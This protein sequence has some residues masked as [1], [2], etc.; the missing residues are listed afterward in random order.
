MI[1][2]LAAEWDAIE[3]LRDD[4]RKGKALIAEVSEK[5]VDIKMPSKYSRLLLPMLNR[6]REAGKKLPGVEAL[7]CEVR[8]IMQKNKRDPSEEDIQKYAWLLRKNCGFIKMKCRRQEDPEFQELC[9]A[10]DPD[11]Q[12]LRVLGVGIVDQINESLAR[13][14][15]AK[16]ARAEDPQV[17]S[18]EDAYDDDDDG[19]DDCSDLASHLS[20]FKAAC[21]ESDVGTERS[22]VPELSDANMDQQVVEVP[23]E[24]PGTVVE[25]PKENRPGTVVEVPKA[26]S[27]PSAVV[28]VPKENSGPGGPQRDAT[29]PQGS[30]GTSAGVK[31]TT[32][33][34]G[35]E[36]D[37][38]EK[39][40]KAD[41]IKQIKERLA[42]LRAKRDRITDPAVKPTTPAPAAVVL[43]GA[44]D[45]A[46]T[47]P[48]D[49][50]AVETPPEQ[51]SDGS[52][53]R[54]VEDRRLEYQGKGQ[55]TK[56]WPGNP[57]SPEDKKVE[58]S[59]PEPFTPDKELCLENNNRLLTDSCV[60]II[61]LLILLMTIN[62]SVQESWAGPVDRVDQLTLRQNKK[63]TDGRGN[64]GR[65]GRGGA[66][67]R[68]RGGGRSSAAAAGTAAD[69][70]KE[71]EPQY[72]TEEWL[73]WYQEPGDYWYETPKKALKTEAAQEPESAM[74]TSKKGNKPKQPKS[75]TEPKSSEKPEEPQ[76]DVEPKSGKKPKE[77][78][79]KAGSAKGKT[80][81][82]AK[83]KGR[84]SKNA[85]S[86]DDV[87]AEELVGKRGRVPDC[88]GIKF[89]PNKKARTADGE[90]T[91]FARRYKPATP[92]KAQRWE[93]IRNCFRT[94]VLPKISGSRTL[95]EDNVASCVD[96]CCKKYI[97][98]ARAKAASTRGNKWKEFVLCLLLLLF[99]YTEDE[100]AQDY[101][102]LEF[103]AGRARTTAAMR[104]KSFKAARFDK[105]YNESVL[106]IYLVTGL[107]GTWFV[108]QPNQSVLEYYPSFRKMI[109]DLYNIRGIRHEMVDVPL[110]IGDSQ[111][112]YP[113]RFAFYLAHHCEL[114]KASA[115]G[116]PEELE[117]AQS[118]PDNAAATWCA[119]DADA[120]L[121]EAPTI[122]E[123]DDE[124]VNAFFGSMTLTVVKTEP[125]DESP[126]KDKARPRG[127]GS[128]A[129]PSDAPAVDSKAP[130]TSRPIATPARAPAVPG[131]IKLESNLKEKLLLA[132]RSRLNRM[133]KPHKKKK[134]LEAPESARRYWE[135]VF[136]QRLEKIITKK[137][138]YTMKVAEGWYSGARYRRNLYDD[139]DEYWASAPVEIPE[140][141]FKGVS[142][143]HKSKVSEAS[144][145]N[146]SS[147]SQTNKDRHI[148][149]LQS[150]VVKMEEQH[151]S[152]A[153]KYLDKKDTETTKRAPPKNNN[154]RP[155]KASCSSTV[156]AARRVIADIGERAAASSGG[157]LELSKCREHDAE[158]DTHRLF[159]ERLHLS[160]EKWAWF[161]G[162]QD[163]PIFS[164]AREGLVSLERT[165]GWPK[166]VIEE[167]G[168]LGL[169]VQQCKD[170]N[171]FVLHEGV[172]DRRSGEKFHA[173]IL[174]VTGDWQWLVKSGKLG[175]NYNHVVKSTKEA[176]NPEGICHLC[177]AGQRG[178]SFEHLDTRT[179]SWLSTFLRQDPFLHPRSPLADL[180]HEPGKAATIFKFDVWHTCHL[181]VCKALAGSGLA[182]L[183][184]T[185]PGRSKDA[186]FE[187]LSND[188]LHWCAQN[189]RQALLTKI[190]KETV[191]WDKNSSY[192]K[193]SWYKG[194]LST[195]MC[196][197]IEAVTKDAEFEDELLTKCGEAVQ[198]LNQFISGLYQG[199][200]FLDSATAR[201]LGEYGLR[202]LRRYTWCARIHGTAVAVPIL[203]EGSDAG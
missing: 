119:S 61:Y 78:K 1:E 139:V 45:S 143:Y 57:P 151:E 146:A 90:A 185:F 154:A 32:F 183:S 80:K 115:E 106:L 19:T 40:L 152:N 9:L 202:F 66:R 193:A 76:S 11:L 149:V 36:P 168:A 35:V 48:Y 13:R 174:A 98:Q 5:Q 163:H 15:A 184:E 86:T 123:I 81:A 41:R 138:K 25:V 142:A 127:D 95:Y 77:P 172:F 113:P 42:K 38:R 167:E 51:T 56:P 153:K 27:G 128:A 171:D 29:A 44:M 99:S 112:E 175:R 18:D 16:A 132:A 188:Y 68:G 116:L 107:G 164:M 157:L 54:A 150:W 65:G 118:N 189:H 43:T 50:D 161:V 196:E 177:Q 14:R 136:L 37:A 101:D 64:R 73:Q 84:A 46:D 170:E 85:K 74:K 158:N 49:M 166:N 88:A 31:K 160:L 134:G 104:N 24:S 92:F 124:E 179:P 83:A 135:D 147:G 182:L 169:L 69:D 72:T 108:E 198:A 6:M 53:S 125:A 52:P 133:M 10:L 2:G 114:L 20:D 62:R 181:G 4:L 111:E 203:A 3:S 23:D 102:C 137:E 103:Y 100:L 75:D 130:G 117:A 17:E 96:K 26:N 176:A 155:K 67:G 186:R 192:P 148:E 141:S 194:S 89:Y 55:V 195:T 71:D 109:M 159:V 22:D 94:Q 33:V 60:S 120:A 97:K 190:T 12:E 200:A 165:A 129:P 145:V 87:P 93:A 82:E 47:L 201:T 180:P 91:T 105:K 173:C 7:R 140:G 121:S 79:T 178:H 39:A 126:T 59:T 156:R 30:S 191:G 21:E 8:V 199:E 28:E 197:Y 131:I 144:L 122:P 162:T 70:H 34:P 187:A 63:D 110:R 58:G